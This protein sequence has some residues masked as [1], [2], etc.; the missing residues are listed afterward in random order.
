M[1]FSLCFP[2]T[3]GTFNERDV[4]AGEPQW[5]PLPYKLLK[6]LKTACAQYGVVV[7]YILTLVDSLTNYWMTPYDWF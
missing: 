4:G 6:E 3:F 1:D 5:S 2:T 7:P